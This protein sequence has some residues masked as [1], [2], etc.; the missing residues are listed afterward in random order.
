[1]CSSG[2]CNLGWQPE[3]AS[4]ASYIGLIVTNV[5]PIFKYPKF[6]VR[7]TQHEK[8]ATIIRCS[9]KVEL[10]KN[11]LFFVCSKKKDDG[12]KCDFIQSAK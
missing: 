1:M 4:Y 5:L 6:C 9:S 8:V 11:K 7:S 12:G 2:D 10:L 3:E